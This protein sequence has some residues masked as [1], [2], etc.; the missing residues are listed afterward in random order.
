MTR[1]RLLSLL[2]LGAALIGAPSA[3]AQ[4][5]AASRSPLNTGYLYDFNASIDDGGD[6][7]SHFF[8]I[9][10]TAPLLMEEGRFIGVSAAYY[11]NSYTFS[12]GADG[13][14]ASLDPWE[15]VHT[16]RLA[17][18]IR[19]QLSEN[20]NFFGVPM[21][22]YI[23]EN[24]A[25]FGDALSGGIITGVSYRFGERLT[26]GPGFGYITQ[27]EDDASIFPVILVDWK[28]SDNLSL[29]TGPAVG[30]SLGPGLALNWQ[31]ADRLQFT[32]GARY[33]KLRFRLDE[34][35]RASAG[36]VGEDRGIPV[37]GALSYQASD[38]WRLAL[39]GGVSFGNELLLEDAGGREVIESDYGTQ[40]F[41]GVNAAFTF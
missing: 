18:P 14:F 36:G 37:F 13:S 24:G 5:N 12:G 17:L 27:I 25:D 26:L 31:V 19:W 2:T 28:L 8:H 7:S 20:W 29:S 22:R 32:L 21:V 35:S 41:V 34:S 9:R 39:L 16:I 6:V 1:F 10:G 33:E 4:S 23:G 30:A 38:N 11:L 15:N 40:P 3:G